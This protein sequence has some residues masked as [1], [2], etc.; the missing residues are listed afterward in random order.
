MRERRRRLSE[1]RAELAEAATENA[2]LQEELRA[3]LEAQQE[4]QPCIHRS[5]HL[6]ARLSAPGSGYQSVMRSAC[7]SEPQSVH[8]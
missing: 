1:A 2:R 5:A 8:Q 7:W 3:A 6:W 4:A